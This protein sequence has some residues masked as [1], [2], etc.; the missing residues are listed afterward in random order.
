MRES[1]LQGDSETQFPV[2]VSPILVNLNN[3]T[4]VAKNRRQ[5]KAV[6]KNKA[7]RNTRD[8]RKAIGMKT[9]ER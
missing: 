1:H 8:V 9:D 3:L 2:F 7:M 6:P 4:L 5:A